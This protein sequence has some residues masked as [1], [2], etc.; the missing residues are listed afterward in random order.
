MRGQGVL[1]IIG[2][3]PTQMP[4]DHIFRVNDHY[5]NSIV[6]SGGVPLIFPLSQDRRVFERLLPIVN[7]FVLTGGQELNRS[8]MVCHLA[9]MAMTSSAR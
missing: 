6:L 4:E 1:P 2:I 9:R 3:V 5:I 8:A 7:G